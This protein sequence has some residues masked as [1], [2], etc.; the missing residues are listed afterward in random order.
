MDTEQGERQVIEIVAAS[1]LD[2]LSGD[3]L[4]LPVFEDRV[5][6]P[7]TEEIVAGLGDWIDGYLDGLDFS[8]KVGTTAAVPGSDGFGRILFVGLG[9]EA[10]ADVLRKAAGVVATVS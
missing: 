1:S 10:D 7:G 9:K 3:L 6:G 2:E 5:W 8:G 4:V